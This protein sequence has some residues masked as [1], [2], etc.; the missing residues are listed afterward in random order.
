MRGQDLDLSGGECRGYTLSSSM[1][2]T[3]RLS[4]PAAGADPQRLLGLERLI[5]LIEQHR[6]GRELAV[7]I[8]LHARRDPRAIIG[9]G[10]VRPRFSGDDRCRLDADRVV[11]PA[12]DQ[13]DVHLAWSSTA[14]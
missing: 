6:D 8:D 10:D 9:D 12:L 1:A 2:P 5:Q 3:N 7:D 13:V 14:L 4:G 11:E